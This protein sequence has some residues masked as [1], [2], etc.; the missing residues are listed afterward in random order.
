MTDRMQLGEL[1]HLIDSSSQ[2]AI[3]CWTPV[4]IRCDARRIYSCVD[5]LLTMDQTLNREM[6]GLWVPSFGRH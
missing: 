1:V 5:R 3:G 4:L 6:T 2:S